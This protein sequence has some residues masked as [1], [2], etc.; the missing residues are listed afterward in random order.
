[1][2]MPQLEFDCE[3]SSHERKKKIRKIR[4]EKKG[5][6]NVQVGFIRVR[7]P[8]ERQ[9]QHQ[10]HQR[11]KVVTIGGS[12]LSP[13][14]RNVGVGKFPLMN[15]QSS[16]TRC[17]PSWRADKHPLMLLPPPKVR[18]STA[19]LDSRKQC[20]YFHLNSLFDEWA[21]NHCYVSTFKNVLAS[22]Q[23]LLSSTMTW[24]PTS[25]V[26]RFEVS[27]FSILSHGFF[28][29]ESYFSHYPE[30]TWICKHV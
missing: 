15:S 27:D 16:L 14:L 11:M 2:D 24:N 21:W 18:R 7:Q 30:T 17:F 3:L 12:S 9:E 20:F 5:T 8:L 29:S 23:L 26:T 10:K 13:L 25:K 19:S 4:R 22:T 6:V 1:M 28:E